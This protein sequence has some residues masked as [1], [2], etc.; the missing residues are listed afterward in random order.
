MD[1]IQTINMYLAKCKENLAYHK[2]ENNA[3]ACQKW[4]SRIKTLESAKLVIENV[5]MEQWYNISKKITI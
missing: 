1:A 5:D 3:L 2:H 4:G